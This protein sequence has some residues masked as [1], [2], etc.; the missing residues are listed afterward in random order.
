MR[1]FRLNMTCS[2][3]GLLTVV[4]LCCIVRQGIPVDVCFTID[5]RRDDSQ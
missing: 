1:P 5:G 2:V 4:E 3:V